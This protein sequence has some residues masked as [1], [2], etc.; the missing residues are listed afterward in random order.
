MNKIDTLATTL[1]NA[2]LNATAV[3]PLDAHHLLSM[4]EAYRVQQASIER[5]VARSERIVGV[6]MGFTSEAKMRQMG[7][8][9]QIWGRLTDTMQVGN[10]ASIMLQNYIHPRCEPEVAFRLKHPLP[11]RI[12]DAEAFDAIEAVAPAIE[13]IDSRYEQF[14]FSLTDVI[15]DNASSS[16]FVIGDWVHC[17]ADLSGLD[18]TL[19]IDG[20]LRQAGSSSDILG[21]PLRSLVAA[22]RLAAQAGMPLQAGWIV[23][24]GAATSAEALAPGMRVLAEVN[25]LGTVG[26]SVRAGTR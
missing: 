10:G 16:G 9:D 1:D 11:A 19:T 17:P 6:K 12:S 13:I 4:D 15:A 7:V 2:M 21:N 26:F 25:G 18:V 3:A 14:K 24:A 5:R 20:Q 23:L 22:A 8:H